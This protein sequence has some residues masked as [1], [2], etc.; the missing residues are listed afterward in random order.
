[1]QQVIA[2]GS[3]II[4]YLIAAFC[5]GKNFYR[6]RRYVTYSVWLVSSLAISIHGWLLYHWIDVSAGQNLALVNLLSMVLWLTALLTLL[7]NLRLPVLNLVVFIFPLTALS[8]IVILLF[9]GF[10]VVN[11]AIQTRVLAH[12]LLSVLAFSFICI[13][14]A[15]AI[16]LRLQE[17]CLRKKQTYLMQLLPPLEQ[18][19]AFLF[20]TIGIAFIVLSVLLTTSFIFFHAIFM[21]SLTQKVVLTVASWIVFAVLLIGHY[22]AGW[23][24]KV[25]T[26][27]TLLGFILVAIAYFLSKMLTTLE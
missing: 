3:S 5:Q 27:G 26:H 16:L 12:I 4:L 14:A 19:E 7:S 20:Q 18:M 6:R 24:G 17:H 22:F 25:A 9:P 13:A 21:P 1:M 8:I 11:T 10:T 15:Q 23:R 2:A